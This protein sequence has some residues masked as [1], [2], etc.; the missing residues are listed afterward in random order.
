MLF[1][2]S[3]TTEKQ[4][5]TSNGKALTSGRRLLFRYFRHILGESFAWIQPPLHKNK[6]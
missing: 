1:S 5:E 3:P 6:S 4:L 2:Y